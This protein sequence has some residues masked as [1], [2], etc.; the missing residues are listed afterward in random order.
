MSGLTASAASW[1]RY[2][3][4]GAPGGAST[5]TFP[6]RKPWLHNPPAAGVLQRRGRSPS[7][8]FGRKK[9]G[10]FLYPSKDGYVIIWIGPH[11]HLVVKMMGDPP[12]SKEPMSPTPCCGTI[13][14]SN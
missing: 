12:W 9:F 7:R 10:G 8:E 5:S 11:Y 14:S 13:T 3:G 6:G 2:W 4:W 1:G